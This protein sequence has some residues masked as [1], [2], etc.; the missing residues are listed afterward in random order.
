MLSIILL[1]CLLL[2]IVVCISNHPILI[3]VSYD[4][5]RYNLFQKGLTPYMLKLRQEGTYADYMQNVFPTKTFPNHHSIATGLYPESHG[6][7]DNTFYDPK[8]E[9]VIMFGEDMY[10]YNLD[11]QP[12]WVYSFI[13]SLFMLLLILKLSV[14]H[15]Y[16]FIFSLIGVI[17]TGSTNMKPFFF[18]F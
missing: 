4:G 13:S 15:K 1:Q 5:F 17:V 3:V 16:T 18:Q 11:I 6:V 2:K 12:I 8:L 7:I 14:L 10:K 9:K